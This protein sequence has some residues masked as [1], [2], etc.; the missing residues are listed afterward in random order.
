MAAE[1]P[2]GALE[3]GD[4]G[5]DGGD[6]LLPVFLLGLCPALGV[7][8]GTIAQNALV[9]RE[10][11]TALGTEGGEVG[12]LLHELVQDGDGIQ[13]PGNHLVALRVLAPGG[14]LAVIP[15]NQLPG[16]AVGEHVFVV[17]G[18]IK[19]EHQG[20]FSLREI[21]GVFHHVGLAV[22]AGDLA[23]HTVDVHQNIALVIDAL[24]DF[25]VF[26]R[27]DHIV[28]DAVGLVVPVKG[29]L[30]IGHHR[31]EKQ[32]LHHAVVGSVGHAVPF[33]ALRLDGGIQN[34]VG[35]RRGKRF[36][37]GFLDRVLCVSGG[38]GLSAAGQSKE[39]A[40]QQ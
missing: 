35:L 3:L 26:I 20:L 15:Q 12:V 29:Q 31:V 24:E 11:Q 13:I 25:F 21:E 16:E 32:M 10:T 9:A 37:G 28:I 36:L 2:A 7:R 40:Q 39:Q 17:V 6:L 8:L 19:G 5:L 27:G 23:P 18:I 38:G 22:L 4:D 33:T 30:R 14:D 34:G 1:G